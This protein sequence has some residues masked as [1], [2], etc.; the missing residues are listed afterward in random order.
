VAS[1][2]AAPYEQVAALARQKA[3]AAAQAPLEA[4]YQQTVSKAKIAVNAKYGKWEHRGNNMVVVP[5]QAPTTVSTVP[6]SAG[7]SPFSGNPLG[8]PGG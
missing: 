8:Q 1:R 2:S 4:W 7:E 3:A 6:P 5:P